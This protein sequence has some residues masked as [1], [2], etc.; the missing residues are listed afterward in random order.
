[1]YPLLKD[2]Q[3]EINEDVMIEMDDDHNDQKI[4]TIISDDWRLSVFKEHGELF[5]LKKDPDEMN[6]L[7]ND[8]TCLGVKTK[9][10]LRLTIREISK[11][12]DPVIRDCGF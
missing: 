10:L 7:W 9:L 5:N 6:N 12:K 1:M 3:Q 4:R 11:E 2:P 8:N